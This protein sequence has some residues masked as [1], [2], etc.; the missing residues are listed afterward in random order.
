MVEKKTRK[1]RVE[2][3]KEIEGVLDRNGVAYPF[4]SRIRHCGLCGKDFRTVPVRRYLCARCFNLAR[5]ES[6]S[7][8]HRLLR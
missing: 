7:V 1:R 3:R 8:E 5:E 6:P 4:E 2:R